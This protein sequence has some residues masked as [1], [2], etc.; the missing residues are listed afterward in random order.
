M[1][2]IKPVIECFTRAPFAWFLATAVTYVLALPLYLLK[3][4]LPPQDAMWLATIVFIVSIYPARII[5]GLAYGR[6]V[7]REKR[8]WYDVGW[9][10]RTLMIAL[11]FAYVFLFFFVRDIGEHGNRVLFEH[12]AFL[13][14]WPM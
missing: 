12:H 14:P 11:L 8:A 2:E 10:C 5:T 7:R 3:I 9:L 13:L 1:F 6:A 4:R